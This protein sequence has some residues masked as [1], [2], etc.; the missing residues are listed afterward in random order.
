MG[1]EEERNSRKRQRCGQR[2]GGDTPFLMSGL[3]VCSSRVSLPRAWEP[4]SGTEGQLLGAQCPGCVQSGS[5]RNAQLC[6]PRHPSGAERACGVSCAVRG[7]LLKPCLP[8]PSYSRQE[9]LPG[10]DHQDETMVN[11]TFLWILFFSVKVFV[12]YNVIFIIP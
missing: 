11:L 4:H 9:G 12:F 7:L 6:R 8:L 3:W 10:Q 2:L 1:R 5:C